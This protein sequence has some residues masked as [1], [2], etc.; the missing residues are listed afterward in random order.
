MPD[1][2]KPAEAP[3]SDEIE[4]LK[5]IFYEFFVKETDNKSHS[6]SHY[7]PKY[8]EKNPNEPLFSLEPELSQNGLNSGRNSIARRPSKIV[9]PPNIPLTELLEIE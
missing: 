3:R 9:V 5:K 2:D 4:E 8:Y 7:Q 6:E 1:E